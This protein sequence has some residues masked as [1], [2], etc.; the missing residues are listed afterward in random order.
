[1]Y[2]WVFAWRYLHTKLIAVFG[3][4]SVMLCVAMVLV[5]LSVMGGFLDS[6]KSR[7]RGLL[8][9]IVLENGTLQGFPYYQQFAEH[10]T[11]ELPDVV[12]MATPTVISYG[13]LRVTSTSYTKPVRVFGIKLNEFSQVSDFR[14]GLNYDHYFPGTTRL[15]K[16]RMPVVSIDEQDRVTLPKEFREANARWRDSET[17]AQAIKEF[18][19]N[20]VAFSRMQDDVISGKPTAFTSFALGFGEAGYVGPELDGLIVGADLLYDRRPDGNFYRYLVRGSRLALTLLPLTPSGNLTGEPPVKVP[21][22]LADD[23]RSGMYE[24]DSMHAYGDFDMLQHKLA[25]D[26]QPLE[27]GGM[28]EPRASQLLISL[29]PGV[30]LDDAAKKILKVWDEFRLGLAADDLSYE[31]IQQISTA[32]IKTWED[33]QRPFIAAVEKEKVLVTLLFCLISVVAIVLVGCIFYMIVEKKTRDIG[34]LKAIG[35]TNQG[36]ASIFLAYASAVGVVGSLLGLALG[37]AFVWN[38]NDIQ[39][40]LAMLNPSLRVWKPEVYSFDKIPEVVKTWDAIS[41]C[42]V[43]MV[44]TVVGSLIPAALAA[45]VWPVKALR[46]E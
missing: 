21:V 19:A 4:A 2:K 45:R 24:I 23:S 29:K 3:I 17:D 7:S 20:P 36:V 10:L 34:I 8:S 22:R 44:S 43:A 38:V 6:V 42:I 37:C 31:D 18:D 32:D 9:D 28:T 35:A 25:M 26:A 40:L 16:Q 33:I 5:V 30:P 41:V 27:D 13:I 39:D 15:G 12:K 46:Y 14:K 1:M 11:E